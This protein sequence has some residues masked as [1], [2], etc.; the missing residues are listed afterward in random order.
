M[1]RSSLISL[2]LFFFHSPYLLDFSAAIDTS[3]PILLDFS[4]GS[5][6]KESTWM[7]ETWIWPLGQEDSLEKGMATH[8]SSILAWRISWTRSLVGY[9]PGGRKESNM[10]DTFIQFYGFSYFPDVGDSKI[11]LK[12]GRFSRAPD[13]NGW[14]PALQTAPCGWPDPLS[15]HEANRMSCPPS[16]LVASLLVAS[17]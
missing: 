8:S 6:S 3:Y 16:V 5:D 13:L 9:S 15:Q 11:Y 17:D 10:T 14:P 2:S 12:P 7:Q 1:V 4:C